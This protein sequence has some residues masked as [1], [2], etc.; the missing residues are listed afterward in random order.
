MSRLRYTGVL[1]IAGTL[2]ACGGEE[3]GV[4]GLQVE[5]RDGETGA[6][7]AY[8]AMLVVSD[9]TYSDTVRGWELYA[10]L[11]PATQSYLPA[12]F[13]RAGSYDVEVS[14]P[15]YRAWRRTAVEVGVSGVP[16]PMDGEELVRTTTLIAQLERE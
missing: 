11:D 16:S 9:G 3:M 7:V 6:P 14:H 5:V 1:L 4:F 15:E 2:V 13:Q 12:L 10:G 8:D